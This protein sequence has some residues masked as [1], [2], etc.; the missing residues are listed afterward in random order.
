M[1]NHAC[2]RGCS[3]T[4]YSHP[5]HPTVCPFFWMLLVC[6]VIQLLCVFIVLLCTLGL[7]M[8]L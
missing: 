7:G 3:C 8:Q 2:W 6:P 4:L 1:C 5:W